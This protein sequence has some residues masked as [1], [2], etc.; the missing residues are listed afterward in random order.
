[1]AYALEHRAEILGEL[2]GLV[3]RWNRLGRP[4]GAADHRCAAWARTVGGIAAAAGL[5][6]FLD[7]YAEAAGSFNQALDELAALAEAAARIGAP[8]GA[9]IVPSRGGDDDEENAHDDD[10]PAPPGLAAAAW[11]SLFRTSGAKGEALATA[12]SNQ[13]RSTI[14]GQFLRLNLGRPVRIQAQGRPALAQLREVG[15]GHNRRGY[16]FE[17]AWARERPPACPPSTPPKPAG[18]GQATPRPREVRQ[19]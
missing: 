18:T 8:E 12:K 15:L 17:V 9:A 3:L 2:A 19:I 14:I 13:A 7:N 1:V 16:F 11:D 5:P 4:P 6:G 10:E